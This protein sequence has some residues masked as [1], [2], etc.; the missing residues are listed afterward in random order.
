MAI[1]NRNV[2]KVPREKKR[3]QMYLDGLVASGVEFNINMNHVMRTIIDTFL[4]VP[5]ISSCLA[6]HYLNSLKQLIRVD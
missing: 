3:K 1:P 2:S 5:K 6:L 4:I